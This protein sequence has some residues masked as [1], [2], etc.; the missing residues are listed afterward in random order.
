MIA[1]R[2]TGKPTGVK[3]SNCLNMLRSGNSADR[4]EN[5]AYM[6]EKNGRE[7]SLQFCKD[8]VEMY[9]DTYLTR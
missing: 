6:T 3:L 2:R 4:N 8:V 7:Y 1:G 9:G 5:V